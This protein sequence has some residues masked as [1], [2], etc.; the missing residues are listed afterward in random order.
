VQATL[1]SAPRIVTTAPDG[2]QFVHYDLSALG[3]RLIPPRR[4]PLGKRLFWSVLLLVLR[5][6]RGR[7]W[8]QRRYGG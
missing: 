2:R 3:A 6:E 1:A 7:R 8:V 4:V 5:T